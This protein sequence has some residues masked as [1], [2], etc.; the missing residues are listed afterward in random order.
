MNRLAIFDCDG[1]LV[2][3]Q[4]NICAALEACFAAAGLPPPP[5]EKTRRVVGLSLIEAMQAMAPDAPPALHAELAEEYKLAF[6][7]L[8]LNGSVDE[9][10][11]AGVAELLDALEADG[12]LLGV[13]TG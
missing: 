12:F 8:R 11:F 10:L 4:H 1:T 3:S 9:P 5:Q 2:D 7:R 13:A 6:Q